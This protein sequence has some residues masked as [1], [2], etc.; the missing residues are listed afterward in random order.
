MKFIVRRASLIDIDETQKPCDGAKKEL[1]EKWE[2]YFFSEEFYNKKD[3]NDLWR[4]T[5]KDHA[6][7]KND[8]ISG[9]TRRIGNIEKWVIEIKDLEELVLF[10]DKNGRII[11]SDFF[12]NLNY[13]EIIIYDHYMED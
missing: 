7:I 5:G 13:K 8:E 3:K 4:N 12:E 2:T 9:I 10:I 1:I 11:L 6:T